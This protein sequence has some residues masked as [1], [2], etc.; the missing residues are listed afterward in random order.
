MQ[1]EV[2]NEDGEI[3]SEIEYYFNWERFLGHVRF[4]HH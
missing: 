1:V 3:G 2:G 4:S